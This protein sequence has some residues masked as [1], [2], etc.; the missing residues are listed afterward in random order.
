MAFCPN[1]GFNMGDANFCP[2]C[3]QANVLKDNVA[4]ASETT[5]VA[6]SAAHAATKSAKALP[7][8]TPLKSPSFIFMLVLAVIGIVLLYVDGFFKY[9]YC[10][11]VNGYGDIDT[12]TGSYAEL[13]DSILYQLLMILFLVAPAV[14]AIVNIKCAKKYLPW[15]GLGTACGGVGLA[16]YIDYAG[17]EI[18]S[19]YNSGYLVNGDE[20]VSWAEYNGALAPFYI[21][22]ALFVVMAA[23][24]LL[25]ALGKPVFGNAFTKVTASASG[26]YEE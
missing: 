1:C 12:F 2:N 15:I 19:Y 5:F 3:G 25:D 20:F 13:V 18:F 23:L 7:K 26:G 8:N 22:V 11:K 21:L 10:Y 16:F 17:K 6:D 9:L 24:S 14:I 4:P